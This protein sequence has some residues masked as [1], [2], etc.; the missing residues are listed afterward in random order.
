MPK[1]HRVKRQ[2]YVAHL[3]K[4]EKERETYLAKRRALKRS[5][6]TDCEEAMCETHNRVEAGV[7]K[8]RRTEAD[9]STAVNATSEE[10]AVQHA[11]STPV[12]AARSAATAEAGPAKRDFFSTKPFAELMKASAASAQISDAALSDMPAT[13][14][15]AKKTLKRRHY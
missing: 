14:I 4:L 9:A 5:R 13:V 8:K 7:A 10:E 15:S 11:H 6:E 3:C 1:K 2:N 12:T